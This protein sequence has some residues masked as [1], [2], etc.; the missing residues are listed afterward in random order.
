MISTNKFLAL[1]LSLALASVVQA[2]E[3]H[4]HAPSTTSQAKIIQLNTQPKTWLTSAGTVVRMKHAEPEI[5]QHF[6]TFVDSNTIELRWDNEYLFIESNG[7]PRHEMMVGITAWQQQIPIPQNYTGDNAWRIPLKPVPADKPMSTKT[8]FFRGAIAIAVNGIPIFNPIKNNGKTDTKLAGELDEFGGHCGRAD[9]YHY[10]LPPLHLEKFVGSGKPIAFALDGYPILGLQS[11][12]EA[13]QSKLDWLNGHKDENGNYHYHST[14]TY[15]YLNGGFYGEVIERDGQVDPQPRAEG[16]RPALQGLRGAEITG[17]KKSNDGKSVSVKYI[18]RNEMRSVSYKTDDFTNYEFL[19]DN[20]QQG[21]STETYSVR[22][23]NR[24]KRGQGNQDNRKPQQEGQRGNKPNRREKERR[25]GGGKRGMAESRNGKQD[26]G[27]LSPQTNDGPRQPWI[28]V[29]AD[30]IDLNNDKII[31]RDEMVAESEKA[32]VGYDKNSDG[33][34][35]EAELSGRGGSKSAMGGFLRGHSQEIDRD[36]DG[37]LTREEAVG[38]ARRMFEKMDGNQDGMINATELAAA[39]RSGDD[40]TNNSNRRGKQKQGNAKN[41]DDMSRVGSQQEGANQ[42]DAN[43]D[44]ERNGQQKGN[45]QRG[46]K[47]QSGSRLGGYETP[48]P[49]NN[50]PKHDY[51]ILLGRPTDTSITV[52]VLLFDNADALISYGDSPDEISTNTKPH[53]VVAGTPVEIEIDGLKPNQDYFYQLKYRNAGQTQTKTSNVYSFNTQRAP[54]SSFRFTVQADSHL[55]ENTSGDVYLTTLRNALRDDSDF[56]VALGDTFMTGKYVRPELAEP[57]YLAQRY[58]LGS[59]C[60]STPLFFCLGN[61]DGESSKGGRGKSKSGGKNRNRD[62]QEIVENP[63]RNWSVDARKKYIPNPFPNLKDTKSFYSG[64]EVIVD[65]VGQIEDYYAWDWG[66][67]LFIVLDP[68]WYSGGQSRTEG[69]HWHQTLGDAQYRWLEKTLSTSK[70]KFKFVFIHHLIGG[71][72][73][74]NRGGVHSAPFFEWGGKELDGTDTFSKN[75]PKWKLPIHDL[76][77]KNDVSVVFHGHDHLYAKEE[78]DGIIYQAVPQP[79]HP[80]FGNVRSAEEYG[81]HG[82]VISSSGHLRISVSSDFARVDYVRAY[83]PKDETSQRT[84]GEIG[85]SYLIE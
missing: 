54:T 13:S 77:V 5:T 52:S 29:H 44:R 60:H 83:L 23:N 85:S 46:G 16:I 74:N 35:T 45:Q 31:S 84:N 61:H 49:A 37:V 82:E 2:H 50:V 40:K 36:G 62:D 79:G 14:L 8:G 70:A 76:L 63:T 51:N 75:R 11:T 57:Q 24:G 39:K 66:N 58:Y 53:K 4:T 33:K 73:R 26:Q 25:G 1:S 22:S 34:L 43:Q 80:R 10:H 15:P 48:P 72:D 41:R 56:H 67:S 55:D 78:L 6:Q 7:M 19:F 27:Q 28:I 21:K 17:F 64:N 68:F 30:E 12:T 69:N 20:G 38:N 32:F 81:Y 47:N 42:K 65:N 3:G 59:L 71:A 18:L 9:D